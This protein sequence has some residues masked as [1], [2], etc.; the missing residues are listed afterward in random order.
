MTR[1][2]TAKCAACGKRFDLPPPGTRGMVPANCKRDECTK[3]R[4]AARQRERRATDPEYAERLRSASKKHYAKPEVKEK[5]RK[6]EFDKY[7]TDP[8]WRARHV[9]RVKR[10]QGRAK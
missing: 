9:E 5:R 1:N 8:A 4:R 7:H 10:W 3:A 6:W 2:K